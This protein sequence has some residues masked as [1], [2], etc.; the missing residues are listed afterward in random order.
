MIRIGFSSLLCSWVCYAILFII[1]FA[2]CRQWKRD[3]ERR[4][5]QANKNKNCKSQKKKHNSWR[6]IWKAIEVKYFSNVN[7][8]SNARKTKWRER[9]KNGNI[10]RFPNRIVNQWIWNIGY[11]HGN[12]NF[13]R[14][15]S[16]NVNVA[17]VHFDTPKLIW[18]FLLKIKTKEEYLRKPLRI[19]GLYTIK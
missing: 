7:V 2:E 5:Q 15:L 11:A 14:K 6:R 12:E 10:F 3:R 16:E 13:G 8:R 17:V 9:E 19:I 18:I 4:K 1:A